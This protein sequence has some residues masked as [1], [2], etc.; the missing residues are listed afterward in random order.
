MGVLIMQDNAAPHPIEDWGH[1]A[2]PTSTEYPALADAQRFSEEI[3]SAAVPGA[4]MLTLPS[5]E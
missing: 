4:M 1:W 3:G 5:F 2:P